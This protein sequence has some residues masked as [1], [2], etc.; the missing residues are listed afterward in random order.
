MSL[1]IFIYNKCLH[2]VYKGN[3]RSNKNYTEKKRNIRYTHK[4]CGVSIKYTNKLEF[5]NGL[6][7]VNVLI[8]A[9]IALASTN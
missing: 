5:D 7:C 2:A 1:G 6:N 9:S 8:K 3:L 4:I